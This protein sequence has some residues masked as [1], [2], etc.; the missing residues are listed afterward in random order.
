MSFLFQLALAVGVVASMV[1]HYM[2]KG[3]TD[4]MAEKIADLIDEGEALAKGQPPKA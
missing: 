2:A 3:K 4:S 1:L